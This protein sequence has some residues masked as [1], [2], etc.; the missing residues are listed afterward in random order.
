MEIKFLQA[1]NL[2]ISELRLINWENINNR[3]N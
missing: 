1:S 2:V 3:T